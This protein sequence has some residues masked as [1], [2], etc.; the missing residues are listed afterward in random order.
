MNWY[1]IFRTSDSSSGL[2]DIGPYHN[3]ILLG[4]G[5]N[6]CTYFDSSTGHAIKQTKS[7]SE[8][9][10]AEDLINHNFP[11]FPKIYKTFQ[12]EQTWVIE[13]EE[14]PSLS[15]EEQDLL[16]IAQ[17]AL[18]EVGYNLEE[19][20]GQ[21]YKTLELWKISDAL[22]NHAIYLSLKLLKLIS[23]VEEIGGL[24]G[25]IRGDNIGIRDGNFVVRDVDV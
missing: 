12:L 9:A 19:F 6:G 1:K 23:S 20:P 15:E 24:P 7:D 16:D 3:L 13:R 5:E 17:E 21:L 8:A 14:I 22:Y 2:Y 18:E 10:K 4:C 11:F 25:E